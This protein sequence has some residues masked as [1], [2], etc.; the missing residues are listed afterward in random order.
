MSNTNTSDSKHT[1]VLN[2]VTLTLNINNI[3]TGNVRVLGVGTASSLSGQPS[4]LAPDLQIG[5]AT[6]SNTYVT[7]G[8]LTITAGS[9]SAALAP[10]GLII[11]APGTSSGT[12]SACTLTSTSLSIDSIQ[13]SCVVAGGF[14]VSSFTGVGTS[15]TYTGSVS[16]TSGTVTSWVGQTLSASAA[17]LVLSYGTLAGAT[18]SA[19]SLSIGTIQASQVV[20]GGYTVSGTISASSVTGLGSLALQGSLSTSQL[21][22]SISAASVSGLGSLAYLSSLS[23]SAVYGLSSYTGATFTGSLSTS[24]LFGSISAA[25]V[26]GLG[27]LAGLNSLSASAVY[28]SFSTLACVTATVSNQVLAYQVIANDRVQGYVGTFL[29]SVNT[30]QANVSGGG[31]VCAGNVSSTGTITAQVVVANGVTLTGGSGGGGSFSG[32]LSAASVYGTLPSAQVAG[33][34]LSG[35]TLTISGVSCGTLTSSGV[36]NTGGLYNTNGYVTNYCNGQDAILTAQCN[37]AVHYAYLRASAG[38]GTLTGYVAETNTGNMILNNGGRGVSIQETT[39]V[40]GNLAVGGNASVSGVVNAYNLTANNQVQ[41]YVGSFLAAVNTYQVN[42]SGGGLNVGGV[43]TVSGTIYGNALSVANGV[44]GNYA[45]LTATV[46]ANAA[47]LTGGGLCVSPFASVTGLLSVSNN[48]A[49]GPVYAQVINTNSTGTLSYAAFLMR[50]GTPGSGGQYNIV[51]DTAQYASPISRA[52]RVTH[53]NDNGDI[54]LSTPTSNS[55]V[56]QPTGQSSYAAWSGNDSTG[57]SQTIYSATTAAV[58]MLYCSAIVTSTP[59]AVAYIA[60]NGSIYYRG[61]LVSLSDRAAKR[62]VREHKPVLQHLRRVQV[63]DYSMLHEAP[64]AVRRSGV[65]AQDVEAIPH[66]GDL[67]HDFQHDDDTTYKG[68]SYAGLIPLLLKGLQELAARVEALEKLV[69]PT[70]KTP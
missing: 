14:T 8:S 7:P 65:I 13:A 70:S 47:S 53:R 63:V 56:C 50:A 40:T 3:N 1:E 18:L 57:F 10:T 39:S 69:P 52:N 51:Y 64:G 5:S 25:S 67:V 17:S 26:S 11:A 27:S 20:A 55:V 9:A 6:G 54:Y 2:N 33:L 4:I 28:G 49:N 45:T 60:S 23:A 36:N 34:T 61:S 46:F 29:S 12:L 43:A 66:V 37:D 58:N 62:D 68:F 15:L 16:T 24:S 44:A 59:V 41:G 38:N 35:G 22:G 31:I 30:Y 21:F 32:S 19:T 48:V 42:V